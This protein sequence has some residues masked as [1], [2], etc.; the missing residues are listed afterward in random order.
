MKF[1]QFIMVSALIAGL[2]FA[3]NWNADTAKAKIDF[4]VKG[5]FG[6]VH[7][8]FTGLKATIQFDEKSLAGSSVVASVESKTVSTGVSLRNHD[9][10]NKEMWFNSE[11]YPTISFH[12][13]KIEKTATGFTAQGSL[14]IKATSKEI[15]IPFTFTDK[16]NAGVFKAQ[17]HINRE[18][19]K[20]GNKGGSVGDDITITL[21]VPVKK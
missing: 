14:T 10:T 7:G 2:P 12:S 13:K 3:G 21:E 8:S 18:D 1:K 15:T 20:L 16:A 5:P 17:F 11:K 19:Y 6:T 4:S 9:L